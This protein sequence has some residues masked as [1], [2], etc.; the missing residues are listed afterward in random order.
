MAT[1]ASTRVDTDNG[2]TSKVLASYKRGRVTLTAITDLTTSYKELVVTGLS[3]AEGFIDVG[4]FLS[5]SLIG[6]LTSAAD[7]NVLLRGWYYNSKDVAIA[8]GI[9][10]FAETTLASTGEVA[11][12]FA[13]N[14]RGGY[15]VIQIKAAATPTAGAFYLDYCFK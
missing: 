15:I 10:L 7:Q 14:I 8:S 6:E 11:S 2:A 4:A 3:D 13:D 5:G 1:T 9:E 12:L